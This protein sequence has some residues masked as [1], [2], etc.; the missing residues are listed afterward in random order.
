MSSYGVVVIGGGPIG[1]VAARVA[2]E[3]GASV[4]LVERRAEIRGPS[5]CTGL[6]S[7]HALTALGASG[8]SILRSIRG[9]VVHGPTARVALHA[10]DDK[11]VVVDRAALERELLDRARAAGVAVRLGTAAVGARRG[12]VELRG[13]QDDGAVA[14]G[15]VIGADGP[16]GDTARWFGLPRPAEVLRAVQT[17]VDAEGAG[18]TV[19]VFLGRDVAPGFFAWAVPAE[20]GRWRV[21]LAVSDPQDP[22]E[23]LPRLIERRFPDARKVS[24]IAAPIPL[25]PLAPIVGD[26]VILVGDAAAHVKPWSGGGLYVGGVCAR[27][28]GRAAAR[29]AR[30]GD[31]SSVRLAEYEEACRRAVGGDLRFGAMARSLLRRMPDA[32]LDAAVSALGNEELGGFVAR[33]ADIDHPSRLVSRAISHP[34]LWPSLVLLWAAVRN[35]DRIDGDDAM[36]RLS[37]SSMGP[38]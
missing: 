34:R 4:L 6:V 27:L 10:E 26:G 17:E 21:G 18:D 29:A 14:A 31:V 30:D 3:E 8:Q 19:E 5:A 12:A 35:A 2:A 23:F 24:A 16:E 25:P 7:A 11:A 22:S 20:P 36:G 28:A 1:A 37:S 9:V 32:A 13:G 38:V 15:V 33:E